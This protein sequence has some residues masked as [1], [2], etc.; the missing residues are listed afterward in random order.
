M[1]HCRNFSVVRLLGVLPVYLVLAAFAV[2]ANA[3]TFTHTITGSSVILSWKCS[4]IYCNLKR[5]STLLKQSNLSSD[6][7]SITLSP[8]SYTF[9]L[10]TYQSG[11]M[12]GPG[13]VETLQKT[14]TVLNTPPAVGAITVPSSDVDGLFSV[15]W[16]SVS[17]A[18][19]YRLEQKF[20]SGAWQPVYS[21][22]ELT[23]P[24]VVTSGTYVYRV[25][26][27]AN[28]MCSGYKN[29]ATV[30]V[31]GTKTDYSSR[32]I[33]IHTDLLGSPAA[34]TTTAGNENQ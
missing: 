30:N 29:S 20:N 3:S 24:A 1:E 12:A 25:Q 9:N 4:G 31:A 23:Y 7:Y 16:S 32:V 5:S 15:T 13:L 6:Q 34:E 2:E 28:D 26:A 10:E 18:N 33:F 22:P 21:G 8:G 17:K 19:S 14:V 11:G 27:C